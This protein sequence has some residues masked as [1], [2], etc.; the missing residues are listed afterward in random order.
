MVL[1]YAI[2]QMECESNWILVDRENH[3]PFES[4]SVRPNEGTVT[5]RACVFYLSCRPSNRTSKLDV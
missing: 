4:V 5:Q 1:K 2:K 3:V